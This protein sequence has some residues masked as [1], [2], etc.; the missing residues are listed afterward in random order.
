AGGREPRQAVGDRYARR[1]PAR[2]GRERAALQDRPPAPAAACGGQARGARG[3]RRGRA[4]RLHRRAP[5]GAVRRRRG[6][7]GGV[8]ARHSARHRPTLRPHQRQPRVAPGRAR[9][10]RRRC[11][12]ARA[13][14]GGGD[15]RGKWSLIRRKLAKVDRALDKAIAAAEIPGAVVLAR[16]PRD[17]ELVEHLS[18]RGLAVV[19]PERIPMTRET[20][21]DLASLTKP[22]A[23]TSAL[24]W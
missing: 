19:R 8:R 22:I 7:R 17:G 24:M 21:F 9:Y 15:E 6:S 13:A 5:P 4:H 18:V 20:I 11:G 2:G 10:A 1:D 16:M 14:R 12:D 23:T 3:P